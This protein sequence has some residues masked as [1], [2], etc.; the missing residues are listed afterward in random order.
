MLT[1]VRPATPLQ[2][3]GNAKTVR[4]NN[5]SRFGKMMRLHFEP[6]GSVAGAVIKTYLL[7][8]SR[9][10]AITDPERNYHIYYQ[11]MA[12][13][14]AANKGS[15]LAGLSIDKVHM[16]NQSK[17]VTL[18]GV[19][20]AK[21]YKETTDS[22]ERLGVSQ[23]SQVRARKAL[24]RRSHQR[25][26]PCH[27]TPRPPCCGSPNPPC[28][29]TFHAPLATAPDTLHPTLCTRPSARHLPLDVCRTRSSRLWQPSSASGTSRSKTTTTTRHRS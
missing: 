9:A 23:G 2:A 15:L 5:S 14:S 26:S 25:P 17:C 8:K 13:A 3:F 12:G 6:K 11:L 20:D 10:V 4:N 28:H 19:D 27:C 24:A 29:C 7:E 1:P 16:L 21:T 22:M 18:V